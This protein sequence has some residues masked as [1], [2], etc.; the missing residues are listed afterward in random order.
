MPSYIS[1]SVNFP[2]LKRWKNRLLSV[3]CL[4]SLFTFHF[5]HS[6][7]LLPHS[8][9]SPPQYK[10]IS[11]QPFSS[12]SH[13]F[14]L[15]CP[16]FSVSGDVLYIFWYPSDCPP[17]MCTYFPSLS[18]VFS[19]SRVYLSLFLSISFSSSPGLCVC[20]PVCLSVTLLFPTRQ[21]DSLSLWQLTCGNF[22]SLMTRN[23]PITS[24]DVSLP[25]RH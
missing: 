3:G 4:S 15:S 14:I 7:S 22:P 13:I 8:K 2:E 11:L 20:L 23:V 5:S 1:C 17:R 18:S 10:F 9:S 16:S 12:I 24:P 6:L 25:I 19:L 21:E